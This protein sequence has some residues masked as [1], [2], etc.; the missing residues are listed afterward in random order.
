M[1]VMGSLLRRRGASPGQLSEAAP[2]LAPARVPVLPA[3]KGYDPGVPAGGTTVTNTGG[4][5]S[6]MSRQDY[7]ASLYGA[8]IA[9]PWSSA[10][11]D[12][13]ARTC[14]AGG[15]LLSPDAD[16]QQGSRVEPPGIQQLRGLIDYVNPSDDIRQLTTG[17]LADLQVFGDAFVEVV[18]LLGKPVALYPLDAP[19][20]IP[21]ADEHGVISGYTQ[22]LDASRTV[23]FDPHE[24]IHIS[25][26]GLRDGVYGVGPT[27]KAELAIRTWLFTKALLKEYVRKGMP[28]VVHAPFPVGTQPVD[29]ERFRQQ[30]A[31]RNVGIENLGNPIVSIGGGTLQELQASK[32]A[33]LLATLTACR[34]EILSV[35]GVPPA[36][37]G[38]IESGNLGGGTG[39]SQDKTFKVNT[40]QPLTERLLEKLT[41]HLILQAFGVPGWRLRAGEVDWRDDQVVETIRD[42]RLHNGAWSLNDY[43]ADIDLPGIGDAGDIRLLTDRQHMVPWPLMGAFAEAQIAQMAPQ[44]AV[45]LVSAGSQGKPGTKDA[46]SVQ[47]ALPGESG[48]RGPEREAEALAESWRRA[49][50]QRRRQALRDL[51][52]ADDDVA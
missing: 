27:Q 44:G 14:T 31:T 33:E 20:M 17:L 50:Q 4:A 43:L 8:Y 25:M 1:G 42:T 24:V 15:L 28:P 45:Q 46:D 9:C 30:Y 38:V 39:T 52:Q 22:R 19:S 35:Y 23:E 41:F 49:F 36:K 26:G 48:P 7:L 32:A 13:V 10:A 29:T 3:P 2:V 11:V 12:A 51:P 16:D 21:I 5:A 40:C 18:W 34:D 47:K 6:G 37:V